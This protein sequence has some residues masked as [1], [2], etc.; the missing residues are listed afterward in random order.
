MYDFR[1]C[2]AAGLEGF[3]ALDVWTD[4][5]SH[6]TAHPSACR[7]PAA[8]DRRGIRRQRPLSGAATSPQ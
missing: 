5:A 4:N 6:Y 7:V 3:G 8:T 1:Q 2:P